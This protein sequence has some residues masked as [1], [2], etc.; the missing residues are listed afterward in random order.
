MVF[1]LLGEQFCYRSANF[2]DGAQSVEDGAIF[3]LVCFALMSG[4]HI[5]STT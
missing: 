1:S 2:V 5:I 3:Q 4:V